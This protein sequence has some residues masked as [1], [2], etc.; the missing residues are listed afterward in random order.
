[1]KNQA[2]LAKPYLS[3]TR[4]QFENPPH[5]NIRGNLGSKLKL[6]DKS[7]SKRIWKIENKKG[8]KIMQTP[9]RHKV[10]NVY[11]LIERGENLDIKSFS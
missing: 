3:I 11:K 4:H 8:S 2:T 1:M 5:Q 7:F 10:G 6:K 9:E